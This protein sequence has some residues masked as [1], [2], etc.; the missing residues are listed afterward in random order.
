MGQNVI[1]IASAR[2][3]STSLTGAIG[4]QLRKK[5]IWE[6]KTLVKY[7][8]KLAKHIIYHHKYEELKNYIQKNDKVILLTRNNL[9]QVYE[10]FNY[11]RITQGLSFHV[12]YYYDIDEP[13]DVSLMDMIQEQHRDIK[14]LSTELDI[15]Y[16]LYEELYTDN[17]NLFNKAF[18]K[19]GLDINK[20][21]LK[22]HLDIKNKYRKDKPLGLI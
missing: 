7:K 1:I 9:K 15:P 20:D 14:R 10:S 2:S 12:P 21:T 16:L 8:N 6:P 19:I 4:Q 17:L 5:P 18:E 13:I 11:T 22:K 3:G